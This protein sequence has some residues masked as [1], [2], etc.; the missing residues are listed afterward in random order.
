MREGPSA[1]GLGA[2]R[3]AVGDRRC[4][5]TVQRADVGITVVVVV[6]V[7]LDEAKRPGNLCV[8]I[9]EREHAVHAEPCMTTASASSIDKGA[10]DTLVTRETTHAHA[11]TYARARRG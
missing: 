10:S 4:P 11:R 8:Y 7:V 9:S 6:V 1:S 3:S 2:I 5:T